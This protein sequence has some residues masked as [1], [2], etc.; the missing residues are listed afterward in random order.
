[1]LNAFLD[2]FEVKVFS[3]TYK[4]CICAF[5]LSDL[6][7]YRYRHTPRGGSDNVW[8]SPPKDFFSLEGDIFLFK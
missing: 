5:K 7:K 8:Q 4:V 1:M 3:K 6:P 2:S